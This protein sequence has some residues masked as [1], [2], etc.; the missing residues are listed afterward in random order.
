M[1]LPFNW[2]LEVQNGDFLPAARLDPQASLPRHLAVS[3]SF[4]WRLFRSALVFFKNSW[5]AGFS[6]LFSLHKESLR[7][8]GVSSRSRRSERGGGSADRN[9]F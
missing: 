3:A 6:Y 1:N 5:R 9:I 7:P 2:R 8:P 4:L